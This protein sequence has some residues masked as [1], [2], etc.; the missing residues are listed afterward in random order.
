MET[1]TVVR[2]PARIGWHA[3]GAGP[4]VLL[5][6]SLGRGAED[7]CEVGPLVAQAGFRVLAPDPRGIGESEGPMHGLTLYH[8]AEDAA[9]V[10]AAEAVGP[11]LVA[12]HAFGNWVARA[13]SACRPQA[14]RRVALLAASVTQTLDPAMRAAIN[15][16]FDPALSEAERLGH[17]QRGYFAP[18]HDARVW[19]AGWHPPVAAMQREATAATDDHWRRCADRHETLY[20]AAAQDMIAPVPTLEA[21][22]AALG[23]S[24]TLS[25]IEDAGHALLPEQP[26]AVAEALIRFAT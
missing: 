10:L 22:R 5:L 24:V 1:R 16:S 20:V 13:L 26:R 2:G 4:A 12:G 6:A 23:D 17:L 7:F 21:L 3:W 25:V 14:V 19:L 8:L 9:A 15:G 18:G 11:A